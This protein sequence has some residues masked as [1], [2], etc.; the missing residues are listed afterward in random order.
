MDDTSPTRVY[1]RVNL[2]EIFGVDINYPGLIGCLK[3]AFALSKKYVPFKTGLMLSAY[4]MEEVSPTIYEIYFDRNKIVGKKRLGVIVKDYYPQYLVEYSSRM[5]WLDILSYQFYRVLI[6]E[7][8]KLEKDLEYT[9]DVLKNTE[10][11]D[12]DY[13]TDKNNYL[14]DISELEMSGDI[15]KSDKKNTLDIASAYVFFN[16][17]RKIYL[18]KLKEEKEA[19]EKENEKKKQ[20]KEYIQKKKEALASANV[21]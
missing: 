9:P 3:K 8:S 16:S 17:I 2:K 14:G 19:R 5:N 4:T 10:Q 20:L 7:A 1:F 21:D 12:K 11:N 15:A 6:T 13:T 18:E